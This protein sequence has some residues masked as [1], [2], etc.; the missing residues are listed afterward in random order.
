MFKNKKIKT[1]INVLLLVSAVLP[2]IMFILV[3]ANSLSNESDLRFK[4]DIRRVL[5]NL[6]QSSNTYDNILDSACLF[7]ESDDELFE[8]LENEDRFG[9]LVSNVKDITSLA[10]ESLNDFGLYS[11]KTNQFM[12]EEGEVSVSDLSDSSWVKQIKIDSGKIIEI[13]TKVVNDQILV[14]FAKDLVKTTVNEEGKKVSTTVGGMYMTLNLDE[15]LVVAKNMV[16]TNNANIFIVDKN[17]TVLF[18]RTGSYVGR[19]MEQE[20][21]LFDI[22]RGKNKK[23]VE[24]SLSGEDYLSYKEELPLEGI[25][26]VALVPKSDINSAIVESLKP[27]VI[28]GLLTIILV[29]VIGGI[30]SKIISKPFKEVVSNIEPFKEGDF[31]NQIPIKD[32][33]PDEVKYIIMALNDVVIGLTSMLDGIRGASRVV[34]ENS[35]VL[36]DITE[37]S[38]CIVEGIV[39]SSHDISNQTEMNVRKTRELQDVVNN[40]SHEI[41]NVRDLSENVLASSKRV[42][43]LSENGKNSIQEL[44]KSFDENN[45]ITLEVVD[46]I[47]AVSDVSRQINN[48]TNSIRAITKQ[49][50]MLSLNASIEASKAGDAGKGFSVVANQIRSLSEESE[51]STKEIDAYIDS[52]TRTIKTL[53]DKVNSL[54]STNESTFRVVDVTY[55]SFLK[56]ITAINDL[57]SRIDDI[58]SSVLAIETTKNTVA[59]TLDVVSESSKNIS[60]STQG[61]SIS[62]QE[63]S[64]QLE[65]ITATS[66]Q[67]SSL[68]YELKTLLSQFK[69]HEVDSKKLEESEVDLDEE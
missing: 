53:E 6:S 44:K 63:Q 65:E 27:L 12:N 55:D 48:I 3:A 28:F 23:F 51:Q 11:F 32:S 40:L 43:V 47:K 39:A 13:E 38:Y 52:I 67:L 68:V 57:N 9:E 31:R 37:N 56:I 26:I 45:E 36:S 42:S 49:T 16:V 20:D 60:D 64:A 25:S 17:Y 69:I 29:V 1:L 34:E 59:E 15:L 54:T 7:L 66:A 5:G 2:C 33:Y 8:K 46:K 21:W 14:T 30:F 41:E 19:T 61:V 18:D 24:T 22:Y 4:S 62:M 10:G 35:T 50:N 58:T